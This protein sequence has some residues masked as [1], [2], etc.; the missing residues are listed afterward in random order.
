M[1]AEGGWKQNKNRNEFYDSSTYLGWEE[2]GIS[3]WLREAKA[4]KC[5]TSKVT[6]LKDVHGL[7][8][9][10]HMPER[11]EIRQ[12][13][14]DSLETEEMAGEDG[15]IAV[16]KIL[17]DHYQKRWQQFCFWNLER[18]SCTEQTTEPI[19]WWIHH[20]LRKIQTAN[21]AIQDGSWR[22]NT[23]FESVMWSKPGRWWTADCKAWSQ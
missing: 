10:L 16:I 20:V 7:Q 9:A 8:L 18:V 3:T 5:A 2:Q 13:L 4:W 23:W 19:Y 6:G 17:E 21:E 1:V 22:K 11:S 15:W 12:Q 14:F